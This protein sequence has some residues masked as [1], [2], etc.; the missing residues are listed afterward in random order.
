MERIHPLLRVRM[1]RGGGL[2]HR[3]VEGKEGTESL[4]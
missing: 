4:K 2:R 3:R 1:L